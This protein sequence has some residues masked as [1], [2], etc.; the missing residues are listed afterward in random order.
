VPVIH[1]RR[2]LISG[3][4]FLGGRDKPGQDVIWSG[5]PKPGQ[6]I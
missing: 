1:D 5:A 4:V 3:A 2:S 6:R